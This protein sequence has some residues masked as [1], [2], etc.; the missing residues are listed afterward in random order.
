MWGNDCSVEQLEHHNVKF[1]TSYGHG[2]GCPKT[3]TIVTSEI[4]DHRY[5]DQSLKYLENY[6]HCDTE[7]QS[8]KCCWK[9]GIDRFVQQRLAINNNICEVPSHIN[10]TTH[11]K[12]RYALGL[13]GDPTSQ[14]QRKSALNVHWKNWC[15]SWNSNT[16]AT[17]CE[18]L[19]H[20]KRPWCW[21]RLKA[22]GE[23]DDR[24]W[25]SW[26]ASPTQWTWVSVGSGS[27]W[28]TGKPGIQKSMG[29]QKVGHDWATEQLH[30]HFSY[31][32]IGQ[33]NGNPLQYS[34]LEN[35]RDGRAWQAAVYGVAQNQTL[36]QLSSSSTSSKRRG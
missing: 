8:T 20:W 2:S 32:C 22:G 36:K 11:N 28:G 16:L 33:G 9:N 29:S 1:A 7:T 34:C 17:W 13:Q 3:I 21:E 6:T 12:M 10:K 27:W 18:E 25:D 31:S 30:F 35:P 15:W 5:N 24:G 4:A 14:L 26:M 19:T 23:G